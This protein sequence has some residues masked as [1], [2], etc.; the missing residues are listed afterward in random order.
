MLYL[1]LAVKTFVYVDGFNLYYRALRGTRYKWLNLK[2][3]ADDLL[4][5]KHTV[6]AV[7]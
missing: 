7:K 4:G 1:D 6:A 5:P 3:L 2:T